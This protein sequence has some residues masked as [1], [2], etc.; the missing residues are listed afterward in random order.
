M[1][2]GIGEAFCVKSFLNVPVADDRLHAGLT[3]PDIDRDDLV[4][5]A[6]VDEQAAIAQSRLAPIVTAAADHDFQFV[7]P[8]ELNRGDDI[9]LVFDPD[10]NLWRAAG[11]QSIPQVAVDQFGKVRITLRG[12]DAFAG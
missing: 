12:D 11:D 9:L 1:A 10:Y 2:A 3:G 8:R 6:Q 5:F 7:F 4:Q